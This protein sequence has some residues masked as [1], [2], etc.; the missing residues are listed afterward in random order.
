MELKESLYI[1]SNFIEENWS[2]FSFRCKE[3][4]EDPEKVLQTIQT[5][6]SEAQKAL[7]TIQTVTSEAQKAELIDEIFNKKADAIDDHSQAHGEGRLKK[8]E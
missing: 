3:Q 7:Q 6:I 4:D 1:V 8:E 2:A 5:V